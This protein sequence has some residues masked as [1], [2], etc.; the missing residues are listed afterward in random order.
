MRPLPEGLLLFPPGTAPS[1]R[2]L[3]TRSGSGRLFEGQ[4]FPRSVRTHFVGPPPACCSQPIRVAFL[5]LAGCSDTA[6]YLSRR[7][8]IC[9][10]VR[11]GRTF[12]LRSRS[13]TRGYE[14]HGAIATRRLLIFR[15]VNPAAPGIIRFGRR[16]LAENKIKRRDF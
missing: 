1:S 3:S 9:P 5:R 14:K 13:S 15:A 10:R 7:G 6:A 16:G 11:P 4:N 12:R 8:P 2:L